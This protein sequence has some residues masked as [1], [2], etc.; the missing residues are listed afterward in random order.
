MNA[1]SDF[2]PDNTSN[3]ET[4]SRITEQVIYYAT[5]SILSIL[6]TLSFAALS[7]FASPEG[8]S[9]FAFACG[10]L[11]VT[12]LGFGITFII[13]RIFKDHQESY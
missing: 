9:F 10:L 12:S 11:S 5:I 13:I 8:D 6:S 2:N 4:K 1:L 7:T 3:T